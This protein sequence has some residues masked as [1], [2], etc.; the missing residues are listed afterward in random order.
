MGGARAQGISH[1]RCDACVVCAATRT[2]ACGARVEPRHLRQSVSERAT[3][4]AHRMRLTALLATRIPYRDCTWGAFWGWANRQSKQTPPLSAQRALQFTLPH[5]HSSQGRRASSGAKPACEAR[6]ASRTNRHR[7]YTNGA[8]G[9]GAS[10]EG[11]MEGRPTDVRP[12]RPS[13]TM[14]IRETASLDLLAQIAT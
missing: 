1:A 3:A 10:A 12:S 9:N 11:S 6:W 8:L 2:A 4:A 13:V 7:R 14:S 5:G